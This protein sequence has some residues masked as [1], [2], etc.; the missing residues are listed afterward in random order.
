[1]VNFF[2]RAPNTPQITCFNNTSTVNRAF[3][4]KATEKAI[5]WPYFCNFVLFRVVPF[6]SA[7]CG[8]PLSDGR[9]RRCSAL[10]YNIAPPL[11]PLFRSLFT[12]NLWETS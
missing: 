8:L 11:T 6:R 5:F 9:R 4:Y 10:L 7:R 3:R 1:M 12:T 2:F